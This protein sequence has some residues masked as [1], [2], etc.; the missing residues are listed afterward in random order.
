MEELRKKIDECDIEIVN[1]L[2]KRMEVAKEIGL[3]KK[4]NN[5]PIYN[6]EREKILLKKLK[7]MANRDLSEEAIEKIY[8]AII[9]ASKDLQGRI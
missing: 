6:A 3:Y 1:A 5:L 8:T 4:K 7:G 9:D 2:K